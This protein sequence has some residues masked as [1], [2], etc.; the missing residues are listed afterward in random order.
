MKSAKTSTKAPKNKVNTLVQ[1]SELILETLEEEVAIQYKALTIRHLFPK[2]SYQGN[3][4]AM[5]LTQAV[6]LY[7]YQE[8][9]DTLMKDSE[10]RKATRDS[11]DAW[12]VIY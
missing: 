5:A 9:V 6:A 10:S 7:G 2:I 1:M 3:D 11:F 12:E 8:V 4:E